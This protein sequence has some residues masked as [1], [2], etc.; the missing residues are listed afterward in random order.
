MCAEA[1]GYGADKALLL[2][3]PVYANYRTQPF[4][5]AIVP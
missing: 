5:D 4:N 2:D 1:F 3:H